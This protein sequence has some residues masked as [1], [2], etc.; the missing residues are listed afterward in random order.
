MENNDNF[1]QIFFYCLL[2]LFSI[3]KNI[4]I[5]SIFVDHMEASEPKW[6]NNIQIIIGVNSLCLEGLHIWYTVKTKGFS[7]HKK[8]LMMSLYKKK[9]S[10]KIAKLKKDFKLNKG[11]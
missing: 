10:W 3:Q 8:G 1:L 11:L 5:N 4:F 7:K 6:V 9:P 2:L